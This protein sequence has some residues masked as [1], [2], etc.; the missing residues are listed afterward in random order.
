MRGRKGAE[1][2]RGHWGG[3]GCAAEGAVGLAGGGMLGCGAE[4]AVGLAGGG[5]QPVDAAR[6][7]PDGRY[8]S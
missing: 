5:E 1:G 2:M 6:Y 8:G 4:G 3:K 7:V